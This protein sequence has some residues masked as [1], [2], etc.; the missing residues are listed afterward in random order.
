MESVGRPDFVRSFGPIVVGADIGQ[1][2]DPT[3][4]VVA[5]AELQKGPR[6]Q[7]IYNV[8][9][10]ERL[11]L[12]TEYPKV[13]DRVAGIVRSIR[14][15]DDEERIRLWASDLKPTPIWVMADATGVGRPVV[16]LLRDALTGTGAYLTAVTFTAGDG[17]EGSLGSHELRVSKTFFAS[18]LKSLTQT[19]RVH[20]PDT[21]EARELADELQNY[22]LRVSKKANTILGAF[23]HGTHDDLVTALGLAVL[24]ESGLW[25]VQRGGPAWG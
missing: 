25:G 7:V 4:I 2:R 8:R 5:E 19:D 17:I 1:L 12:G 6:R 15:A 11:P 9:H 14:E 21:A 24:D 10:A 22:E 23:K 13:A 3:A 16:E 20:L 18:R